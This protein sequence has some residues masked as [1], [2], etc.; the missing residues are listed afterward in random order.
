MCLDTH[1]PIRM[2]MPMSRQHAPGGP[3]PVMRPY[4]MVSAGQDETH[5][6]L[7]V[8]DEVDVDGEGTVETGQ[9]TRQVA[10]QL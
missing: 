10:H 3:W 2:L 1:N 7:A 4:R 6:K 9:E 5:H 8:L